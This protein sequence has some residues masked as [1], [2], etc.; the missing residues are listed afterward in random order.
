MQRAV[1]VFRNGNNLAVRF[2]VDFKINTDTLYI[3][4]H[5]NGDISLSAQPT[6]SAKA[7]TMFDMLADLPLQNDS[8]FLS[9]K[10]R[11]ID[12]LRDPF[13]ESESC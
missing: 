10:E 4:Q 13:G 7:Q 1:K 5:S 12:P 9:D 6:I 2:P 3:Q 11:L 8:D